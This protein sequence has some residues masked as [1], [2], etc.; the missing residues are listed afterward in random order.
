MKIIL[1][2][3][4]GKLMTVFDKSHLPE[5]IQNRQKEKGTY[6]SPC[7]SVCNYSL[8]TDICQT[9]FMKRAEKVL[10]KRSDEETKLELIGKILSRSENG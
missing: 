3:F 9:C 6:D 2:D 8:D 1:D 10:W 4:I 5:H 7:M